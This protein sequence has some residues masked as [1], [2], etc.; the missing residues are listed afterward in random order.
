MKKQIE[1]ANL[2]ADQDEALPPV[3]RQRSR[4]SRRRI[5]TQTRTRV[6]REASHPRVATRR[7]PGELRSGARTEP[8]YPVI[9][10]TPERKAHVESMLMAIGAGEPCSFGKGVL[11]GEKVETPAGDIIIFVGH[12][13]VDGEWCPLGPAFMTE[14]ALEAAVED[15]RVSLVQPG[16]WQ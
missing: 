14:T 13:R 3:R 8:G 6:L 7:Y 4:P 12:D 1:N 9:G 15:G 11:V 16:S 2:P 5:R 10:V